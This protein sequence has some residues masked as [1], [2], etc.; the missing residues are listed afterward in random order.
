MLVFARKKETRRRVAE[1]KRREFMAAA[2]ALALAPQ[3]AFADGFPAKPVRVIVPYP[4]GGGTDI[5]ARLVTA[6]LS[7]RWKQ[8]VIVENKPGASGVLGSEIVAKSPPD[9]YV[10]LVMTNA[11]TINPNFVKHLPYDTERDFTPITSLVLSAL[12]LAGSSKVGMD[13]MEKYLRLARAEPGKYPWASPEN[14]TRLMGELIRLKAGLKNEN[15]SYKGAAPMLQELAGGHVS[16]GVTTPLS[17][18]AYHRAGTLRILAVT[19]EKRLPLIPDVPTM[20]EVGVNGVERTAWFAMFGPAG[21]PKAL[22]DRLWSD[23]TAVL[24]RPETL[25]RIEDLA[26]QP[27]GEPP[28]AFAR[29]I[30][31]E[32][33]SWREVARE[34]DIEPE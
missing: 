8:T 4:P 33:A 7:E 10:L 2:A 14:T 29:R 3:P 26:S 20:A 6:G 25:S 18:M 24:S 34:A 31:E 21:M 32:L 27:G 9:G 15:V 11:H 1:L 28:E 19:S 22:V 30:K 12:A 13:S 5:V 23:V 17:S 16:V